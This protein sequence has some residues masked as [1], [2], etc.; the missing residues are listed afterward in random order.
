MRRSPA[1]IEARAVE[2]SVVVFL[3]FREEGSIGA[4]GVDERL[5]RLAVRLESERI[6]RLG[7]GAARLRQLLCQSQ[8]L[9][10]KRFEL[11][12]Q[13]GLTIVAAGEHLE[14]AV[15]DV[16]G[17]GSSKRG[18]LVPPRGPPT[19]GAAAGAAA[20][21]EELGG[22]R[23]PRGGGGGGE[24]TRIFRALASVGG[25][26]RAPG[27]GGRTGALTGEPASDVVERTDRA[28]VAVEGARVAGEIAR[29]RRRALQTR[30]G[31]PCTMDASIRLGE[32]WTRL[33][34]LFRI[35]GRTES[36]I[37]R[38]ETEATLLDTA[39]RDRCR[40]RASRHEHA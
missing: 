2:R 20:G 16:L 9:R 36:P 40:Q 33:L 35:K 8:L 26:S 11:T 25:V 27:R 39:E 28:V 34:P 1:L 21:A 13:R 23:A 19:A 7:V 38:G 24:T 10:Q 31:R 18:G 5:E 32:G 15:G 6:R 22:E 3:D 29:G 17:G 37:C 4:E 30:G 12:Q 14:E